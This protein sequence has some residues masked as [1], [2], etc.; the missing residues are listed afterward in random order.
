MKKNLFSR[1]KFFAAG[2]AVATGAA[3]WQ[4]PSV[5]LLAGESDPWDYA[6]TL[7]SRIQTPTFKDQDFLITDFGAVANQEVDSTKAINE[8]IKHCHQQGGGRVVVPEGTYRTGA[9]HLL[10]NVNLHVTEAAT[11]HFYT[12][13]DKYLP[14]VF[15]RFEGTELMN[16]SPLIYAYQ[17]TNIGVTGKGTLDGGAGLDNW[18]KW[19]AGKYGNPPVNHSK[20]KLVAMADKGVPVA[21]RV[22]GDGEQL[23]PSFIQPYL[24]ERVLIED[25]KVRRAPFWQIHPVL[26]KHVTVRGVDVNS[27]FA[28]N[29]GCNPESSRFVLIENCFFDTGDDC[30]AIKSGRNADG[31]RL[32][33]PSED[34]LVRNCQ[35][36]AGH[37]GVVVGSEMSG[38]VRNVYVEDCHMSSP[39][40]WYMLRIKSNSLRGGF[41]K[42]IHVRNIKVGTIGKAAVRIN[43]HYSDGDVGEFAP[44][45]S[46]VSVQNVV[47]DNIRQ[48][49]SL[50]GYERSPITNVKL[51]N[52][53]FK[54][55]QKK[56]VIEHVQNLDLDNV[57]ND[58]KG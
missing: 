9:I 39:D 22:F 49:L 3:A 24:C 7:P 21:D 56:D 14:N 43:F 12:D 37:G 4:V 35:M 26:C 33:V 16:Y 40:L 53:T 27:H 52:V 6:A 20:N 46:N 29:D 45:V 15:T 32:A 47:G 25:V 36:K 58:Y 10:S 17:Q 23:R 41:V 11:L 42:H 19:K 57:F 54:N 30:I 38:G 34:I 28:N 1:R 5:R 55:V 50:R 2:A 44:E 31:R 48:G 18:M 8:A 51:S 13:P